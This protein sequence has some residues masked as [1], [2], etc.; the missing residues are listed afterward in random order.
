MRVI[1]LLPS[2]SSKDA[3]GNEAL[4]IHGALVSLGY[5]SLIYASRIP[6]PQDGVPC[7]D[8]F[9]L[10]DFSPDDLILY[11]FSIGDKLTEFFTALPGRRVLI[12]HNVTP[13]SFFEPYDRQIA[14][15]C[16]AGLQQI[17][18]IVGKVDACWADSEWN[19]SDLIKMGFTCPI[20]VMP[21]LVPFDDYR[22]QPDEGLSCSLGH[23]DG[24]KL[25]FV[26]RIAPNKCQHDV[27]RAFAC[28]KQIYDRD[29]HL[30]LIGS[31]T[32]SDAYFASLLS[33]VMK[34]GV[35]DVHI[36]DSVSFQEL[37]AY[38]RSA[39]I[40]LCQSEHE[41]FCVPLV[42]AMFFDVPIVAYDATA[43]GETMGE[44]TILLDEKDPYVTAAVIDEV[45][46]DP[47]LHESVVEKQR[48]RLKDFEF[49]TLVQLL[50]KNLRI[51]LGTRDE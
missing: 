40:F 13:P 14:G 1:Q 49:S 45:M 25:L 28:Y 6:F 50:E 29:A 37:L 5:E 18:S 9:S 12:Y 48:E 42:E 39:D 19:K 22:G 24:T 30:Y 20:E 43:V 21:I 32:D 41:G 51:A 36:Q 15:T 33:Y 34:L 8:D 38:Y 27:I 11:H 16:R 10:D 46:R 4:S 23:A 7:R 35:S 3:I 31:H 17:R 44:G 47:A 26:G 2:F